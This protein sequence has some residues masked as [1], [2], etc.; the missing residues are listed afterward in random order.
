MIRMFRPEHR[1]NGYR[2]RIGPAIGVELHTF[3][4]QSSKTHA[5]RDSALRWRLLAKVAPSYIQEHG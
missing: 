5:Q 2:D 3:D 1:P 4:P